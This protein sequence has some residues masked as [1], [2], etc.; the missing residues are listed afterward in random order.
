[1]AGI[2]DAH[3]DVRRLQRRLGDVAAGRAELSTAGA[4]L[5][6]HWRQHGGTHRMAARLVGE[7]VR[8]AVLQQL[9][10]WR[11]QLALQLEAL[12]AVKRQR[13]SPEAG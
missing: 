13:R 9:Y 11:E 4:G 3:A 10:G 1:M 2:L 6:A 12:E 7:E 5:A 8:G